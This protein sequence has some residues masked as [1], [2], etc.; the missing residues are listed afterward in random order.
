MEV[1]VRPW[2]FLLAALFLAV[3][4]CTLLAQQANPTFTPGIL[5]ASKKIAEGIADLEKLAA[6]GDTDRR[7]T[8]L[9]ASI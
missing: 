3:S 6:Q 1:S 9:A 4:P 8:L 5:A 2:R 7:L